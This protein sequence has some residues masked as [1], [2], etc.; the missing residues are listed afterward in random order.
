MLGEKIE[1]DD[2]GEILLRLARRPRQSEIQD[3]P[4]RYNGSWFPPGAWDWLY[5]PG[6]WWF[7]YDY[8][9][10][11]GWSDWGCRAARAPGG[12]ATVVGAAGS[13]RR[14][15]SSDWRR[16]HASPSIST[17]PWP[18]PSI[19]IKTINTKSPPKWSM[20]R[21]GRLSAPAG[22]R[23]RKPFQVFAWVDRG[24]YHVDDVDSRR[25]LAQTLDGKPVRGDGNLSLA[26]DRLQGRQAGKKRRS[27]IGILSTDAEGRAT[28]QIK[29][30]EPGQYRLSFKL[31]D[32][33]KR[34]DRRGLSSSRSSA[35][36][37]STASNFRFNDLELIPDRRQYAAA[38]NVNLMV[39]T[40]RPDSAVLLFVR[41]VGRRVSAAEAAAADGQIDRRANR[42]AEARHAEFLRRGA[43][44]RRRQAFSEVR[45]SSFRRNQRMLNV[46]VQP[47]RDIVQAGPAATVSLKLTDPAGHPFVGSA[48]VAIYDKAVEYIS[49]GSNVPEYQSL[50]L[51]MDAAATSR[52]Q[53]RACCVLRQCAS[54]RIENAGCRTLGVFGWRV[55][56]GSA[57]VSA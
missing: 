32:D 22:A 19:P 5:G 10:F 55:G 17:R 29:A 23:G 7:G 47:S 33:Q 12:G 4:L 1:S 37:T 31:T 52:T 34:T 51:A 42:R 11:P 28:L 24:Y 50:L 9:W 26:K 57:A 40:D 13:G 15:R 46:A 39:N 35:G 21:G 41:P 16:W 2:P 56:S 54:E 30:S 43:D 25:L 8:D 36:P 14:A 49:G 38:T 18:R 53:N 3:P 45:R 20:L 48:V 27:A 6:Y 44:D